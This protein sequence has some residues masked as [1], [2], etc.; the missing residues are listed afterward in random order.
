MSAIVSIRIAFLVNRHPRL[1]SIRVD[2][3]HPLGRGPRAWLPV[4]YLCA[5]YD[6]HNAAGI[7]PGDPPMLNCAL[8]AAV[9][10]RAAVN[11]S[12]LTRG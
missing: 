1:P 5:F 7:G 8:T 4:S 10:N 11:I 3:W 12:A 6:R 2:P 9:F